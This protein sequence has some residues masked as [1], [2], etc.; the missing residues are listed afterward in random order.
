[1]KS[2]LSLFSGIGGLCHHGIAAAGLSHKF[3]VQQFVEISPYSQSRLRYEQPQIP[4]HADV[5]NYHCNRGQFDIVCG[6]FPCSGTSN[7][8]NRQG[9]ADHRSALWAEQ[10]RIIQECRPA[11]VEIE[12]P[13]GLLARGMATVL[14]DL[15]QIGYVCEWETIPAY[16][17]GLPHERKRVFIIAYPNGLFNKVIPS[18]WAD[19]V[20]NQTAS[21]RESH[22][23]RSYQ[24]G[25]LTVA[26][27][28]PVGVRKGIPGNYDARRAYGLSCSPRQAAVAWKRIDYLCSLLSNQE[29]VA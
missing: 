12:N 27:G 25:V 20:R 26:H 2:V 4:I 28:V 23:V 14:E 16:C 8:G 5:T 13:T 22:E 3:Q 6:G 21:I 29:A 18:P 24:P 1:M 17:V 10:F 15:S 11:I 19:Q 9:L 7:S